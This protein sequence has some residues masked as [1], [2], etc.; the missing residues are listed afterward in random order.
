MGKNTSFHAA[1]AA[2]ASELE[3]LLTEQDRIEERILA[4]RK[5]MNALATLISQHEGID[6]DFFD[7]A[8]A[9]MRE[10][11]DTSV[12]QDILRVIN[13]SA[14]PLT[15]SEIRAELNELGGSMAEQSNPLATI[16]AVLNRLA[17]SGR[18]QE[19]I[20]HNGKKAWCRIERPAHIGNAIAARMKQF[21]EK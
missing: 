10:V 13:A 16:H 8:T 7:Y 17:E 9:W 15:A 3:S 21:G 11:V 5:T 12:T 4:L 19:T 14:E 20:K 6:K 1:Y 2:A 18:A